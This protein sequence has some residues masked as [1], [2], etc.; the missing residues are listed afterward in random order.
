M[1]FLD[2]RP[3]EKGKNNF[4]D[5]HK[6]PDVLLQHRGQ[7]LESMKDFSRKRNQWEGPELEVV[8]PPILG[9]GE[10][11]TVFI[12]QDERLFYTNDSVVLSWLLLNENELRPKAN[13]RALYTSGFA[14]DCHGFM[15]AVVNGRVKTSY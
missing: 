12:V 9:E 2:F 6:R 15:K 8:V 14:C 5:G 1:Y 13:G 7:F 3:Q 10:R 4:V 11:R